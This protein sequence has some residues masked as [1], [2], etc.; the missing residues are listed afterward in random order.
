VGKCPDEKGLTGE[1]VCL[2]FDFTW[3]STT[4]EKSRQTFKDTGHIEFQNKARKN[5]C[6]SP[7]QFMFYSLQFRAQPLK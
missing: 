6:M 5:A 7:A 3:W 2:A 1:R 4:E